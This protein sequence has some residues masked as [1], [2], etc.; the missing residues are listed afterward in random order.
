MVYVLVLVQDSIP[1]G[2]IEVRV[3]QG[4]TGIDQQAT[5]SSTY[6]QH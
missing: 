1:R 5:A 4:T 2:V 3:H 6:K